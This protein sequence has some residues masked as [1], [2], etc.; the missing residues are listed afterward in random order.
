[1]YSIIIIVGIVIIALYLLY[2]IFPTYYFKF[3]KTNALKNL[4]N[5]KNI[6]LTFDDGVDPVHTEKL[7]DLL[8]EQNVKAAFFILARSVQ[9][10]PCIVD[11]IIN[12][13]H[14]LGLHSLE[15]KNALLKGYFYTKKDFDTSMQ[16]I[17][18]HGYEIKYFRPPWGHI[19]IFTL[20][21]A[22]RYKLDIILWDVMAQD[23]KSSLTS[24]DISNR[25]MKR[26]DNGSIICLHDGRGED[27]APKR[28]ITALETTIPFLKET[29]FNFTKL[30]DING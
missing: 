17:K 21:Y 14:T 11:R 16:I 3:F 9:K 24:H 15:H 2:C 28:T 30:G 8:K 20:I 25:L 12:E 4:G 29:G 23:W 5:T 18:K 7:L 27:N 22:K 10:Y 1:M 6:L 19:N 26:V 13:G